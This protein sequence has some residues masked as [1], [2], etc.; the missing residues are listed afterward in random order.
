MNIED[1]QSGAT[2]SNGVCTDCHAGENPYVVHPAGP[3]N[4]WPDNHPQ[5]WYTPLIKPSWPQNPGPF[6]M[7]AQ[8]PI[9]PLPPANDG[10]C[11]NATS[12]GNAAGSPT[13]WRSIPGR[14][15]NPT[16]AG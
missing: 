5:A 2:L 16:T 3:L 11:L 8:V 10:S 15:A 9:N 14:A 12:K 7:L 6:G 1:F 13:F 4:M